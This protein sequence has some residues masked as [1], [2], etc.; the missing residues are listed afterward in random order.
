MK[1]SMRNESPN[2]YT[3]KELNC[4]ESPLWVRFLGDG[5]I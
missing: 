2:K 1:V 3:K 5:A 4:S